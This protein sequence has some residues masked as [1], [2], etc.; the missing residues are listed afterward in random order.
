MGS[1]GDPAVNGGDA[2]YELGPLSFVLFLYFSKWQKNPRRGEEGRHEHRP[3]IGCMRDHYGG[4]QMGAE[5]RGGAY[6]EFYFLLLRL[7]FSSSKSESNVVE[8]WRAEAQ[9]ATM[10]IVRP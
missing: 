2:I 9:K 5:T 7:L 4:R 6:P 1:P 10:S 3:P 8:T